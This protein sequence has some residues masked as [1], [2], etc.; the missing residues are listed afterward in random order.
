MRK[1]DDHR[2]RRQRRSSRPSRLV[3]HTPVR[4]RRRARSARRSVWASRTI[5]AASS[6]SKRSRFRRRKTGKGTMRFND[7]A[8]SMAQG[9]ASSTQRASLRA[10]TGIDRADFD[11]HVNVVGG[12]NIDG[13]SAG[14]RDLSR[15]LFRDSRRRR[16]RKTSRSPASSRFKARCVRVGGVIEKLY[17]A[18]QAG[19]RAMLIAQG[20]RARGRTQRSRACDVIPVATV[21][22]ALRA[23]RVHGIHQA[24]RAVARS[25][26]ERARK[27]RS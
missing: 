11:L 7:T 20:K 25:R 16:C 3:P 13:P 12:G 22:Q 6:R 4:A 2:G 21:E 1:I 27:S 10:L 17:A 23:L 19:M 9:F 26:T 24:F 14:S 8:G 5:W 15:A 18:R